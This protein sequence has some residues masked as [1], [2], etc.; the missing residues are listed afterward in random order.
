MEGFD[1]LILS[2]GADVE[3]GRYGQ[4]ISLLELGKRETLTGRIR[5]FAS[6][7]LSPLIY[8]IRKLLSRSREKYDL[9]R[10]ELEWRLLK[11]AEERGIPVLGICRGMQ[12]INVYQGGTLHQD[13]RSFYSEYPRIHSVFPLKRVGIESSSKLS[14][15]LGGLESCRVNALNHQGADEI[16][17][18]LSISAQESSGLIQALEHRTYP[19]MLGLQWHPE[20]LPQL[21]EQRRIFDRFVEMARSLRELQ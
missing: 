14:H 19:F 20:Y 21:S 1:G 11:E 17:E 12:L 9:D 10:D 15:I 16:G 4:E 2:G 7:I 6:L 5:K 18:A 3:P 13:L 8:L